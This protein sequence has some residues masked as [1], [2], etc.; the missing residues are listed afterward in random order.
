MRSVGR[1]PLLAPARWVASVALPAVTGPLVHPAG[2][3]PMRWRLAVG[4]ELEV[5]PLA[6]MEA[7]F[8]YLPSVTAAFELGLPHGLGAAPRELRAESA[9]PGVRRHG[10]PDQPRCA[11]GACAQGQVC[12]SIGYCRDCG[13]NGQRC[14]AGSSCMTGRACDS[15]DFCRDCGGPWPR[16]GRDHPLR[17]DPALAAPLS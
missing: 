5:L 9:A 6:L 11:D 7:E 1:A 15:V 13:G 10:G 8:R 3:G 2:P 14:C 4:L 12:D 17:D 16:G